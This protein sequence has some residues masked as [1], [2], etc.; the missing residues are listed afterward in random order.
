GVSGVDVATVLLDFT[1]EP[2]RPDAPE[3][4]PEPAPDSLRLLTDTLVERMTEPAELVRTARRAV[5]GP[6]RAVGQARRLGA[7]LQSLVTRD[8]VAPRTSLNRAVGR[9]RRLDTVRIPL[10]DVK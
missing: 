7:S 3:W 9:H 8:V 4:K 1:P 6:R 2:T 5:R 10:D